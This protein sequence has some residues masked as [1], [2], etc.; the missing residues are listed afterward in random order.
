MEAREAAQSAASTKSSFLANM[1]HEIRTPLNGIVGM[2]DL[3]SRT[4]LDPEQTSFMNGIR[5]STQILMTI[6]NEILDF[7]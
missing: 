7:S 5:S 3:L 6:V 4:H 2:S 1:S